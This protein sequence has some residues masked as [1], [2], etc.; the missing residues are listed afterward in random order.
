MHSYVFFK[1]NGGTSY[2]FGNSCVTKIMSP[3]LVFERD[4]SA[5]IASCTPLGYMGKC[6]A[7]AKQYMYV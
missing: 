4:T 3:G 2:I 7:H 5:P 1:Q 6:N